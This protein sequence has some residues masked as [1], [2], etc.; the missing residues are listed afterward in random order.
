MTCL[1]LLVLDW[2]SSSMSEVVLRTHIQNLVIFS[3]FPGYH[4]HD[5]MELKYTYLEATIMNLEPDN[6]TTKAHIGQVTKQLA[7]QL[8]EYIA[9]HPHE[10]ITRSMKMLLMATESLRKN[11]D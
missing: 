5:K 7:K 8:Q 3:S 11:T 10:K 4:L 9:K 6:A 1:P 2:L